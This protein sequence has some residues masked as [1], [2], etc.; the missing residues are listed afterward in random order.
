MGFGFPKRFTRDELG[1]EL[2]NA[3]PV[4]NVETDVGEDT[5]N[6]AFHQLAGMNLIVPR[7]TLVAEWTG[8]AINVLHQEEAW[9]AK[10]EQ[11]HPVAARA[12][13]GHYTYTFAA[14]Y[15]DESGVALP[16]VLAVARVQVAG[17]GVFADRAA[18]EA[19]VD[20]SNP[21]VVH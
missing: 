4:E 3:Y 18:V 12:A 5:F 20:G 21:L 16:T 6:A 9:N 13:A 8:A 1:P 7:A 11:A 10:R 2:V 19:Y 15:L 17:T 14:S